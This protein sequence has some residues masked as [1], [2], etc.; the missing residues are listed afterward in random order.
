[1][2]LDRSE[3][4]AERREARAQLFRDIL[5]RRT[6]SCV[7]QPILSFHE[8]RIFGY[9]ALI[10]GPKNSIFQSPVDLFDAAELAGSLV[11]LSVICVNTVLRHFSAQRLPGKLFLNISPAVVT[12]PGFD[13]VRAAE[14]L[15]RLGLKAEQV[16]IE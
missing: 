12:S 1:M 5:E 16:I 2:G 8:R 15:G 14:L 11:E 3:V 4:Q 9:E 13:P 10:R 6:L 7:F